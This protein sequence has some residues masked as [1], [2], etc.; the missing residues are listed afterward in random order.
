MIDL[1]KR[2]GIAT[3]AYAPIGANDYSKKT[4]RKMN[5]IADETIVK[6]AEKN[7]KSPA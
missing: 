6:I 2:L 5:A 3:T 4:D 1:H 7:N